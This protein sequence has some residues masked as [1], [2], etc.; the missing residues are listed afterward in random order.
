MSAATLLNLLINGLIEGAVIALPALALTLIMAIARFPQ[1]ATGDIA[2]LGAYVAVGLQALAIAAGIQATLPSMVIGTVGAAIAGAIVS[3]LAWR[4]IFSRLSRAPMVSSLLAA[5]GLAFFLRSLIALVVGHDQRTFAVPLV[6]AWNFNGVRLL[7][8]D[9]VIAITATAVLAAVFIWLRY[10]RSGR[11]LRALA[12]NA[13]LARLS[14]IRTH[15][16]MWQLW[17]I[18]GALSG[19]G[20]V[21]LGVKSVVMPELGWE[22][23]LP[24]FAAMIVGGIGSPVGAVVGALL[25]GVGQELSVQWVGPSYKIV[26]SFAVLLIVLLVRPAGLFGRPEAVR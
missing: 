8:S 4:L 10:S 14:G 11:L 12:D 6:R 17:A 1:A 23:L 15:S 5:I 21:L 13:D 2:T 9:L 24:A 19:L 26:V 16:L 20:G 18:A 3:T 7:P 25:L 22:L